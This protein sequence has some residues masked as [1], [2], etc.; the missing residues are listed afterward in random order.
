MSFPNIYQLLVSFTTLG[1]L[2]YVRSQYTYGILQINAHLFNQSYPF[3]L[4]VIKAR[5]P[6]LQNILNKAAYDGQLKSEHS[7]LLFVAIEYLLTEIV[8]LFPPLSFLL[9]SY[10]Q[11]AL[12]SL[13]FHPFIDVVNHILHLMEDFKVNACPV[14]DIPLAEVLFCSFV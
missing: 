13:L 7:L 8:I 11:A 5:L 10:Y 12:N 6:H 2:Y 9:F 4:F 1:P 3:L 14:V